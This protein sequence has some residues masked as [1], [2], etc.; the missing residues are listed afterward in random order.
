MNQFGTRKSKTMEKQSP[1]RNCQLRVKRT[2]KTYQ[3]ISQINYRI[4]V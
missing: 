4:G 1:S 2:I 3:D